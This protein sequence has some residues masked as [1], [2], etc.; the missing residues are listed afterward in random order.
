M[1]LPDFCGIIGSIH[2]GTFIAV[3]KGKREQDTDTMEEILC[4][5]NRTKKH[6]LQKSGSI[7]FR[8]KIY[9]VCPKAIVI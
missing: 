4:M 7:S 5:E 2:F 8:F 6:G 9:L 1:I 3:K